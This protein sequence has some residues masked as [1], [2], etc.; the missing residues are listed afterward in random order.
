MF[1]GVPTY[2]DP[3]RFWNIIDK[4][5]VNHFYTAPTAIRAMQSF[6]EKFLEKSELSSLKV[7]GSVGEPINEE[8]WNWYNEKVGKNNC[9]IVDTWW[10]TRPKEEL[11][12]KVE[13][14]ISNISP[15][16]KLHTIDNDEKSVESH[17][18]LYN[19][20]LN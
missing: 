20:I 15:K 3:S 14:T 7:I 16:K 1:E 8:A 13:E 2:P 19:E 10:Q 6:G 4:Y 9:P 12:K 18:K 11:S 17:Y 5:N